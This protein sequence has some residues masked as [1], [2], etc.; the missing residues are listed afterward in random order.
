MRKYIMVRKHRTKNMKLNVILAPRYADV[1]KYESRTLEAA[2]LLLCS[3][4]QEG[5][6][7]LLSIRQEI[8]REILPSVS[9][10][11][12]SRPCLASRPPASC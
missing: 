5:R 6:H 9:C 8:V 3:P 12:T 7:P 10:I 4:S 11:V 2:P 1:M